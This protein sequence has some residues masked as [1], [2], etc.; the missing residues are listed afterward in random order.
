M[1]E[2]ADIMR[3]EGAG[4]ARAPGAPPGPS[5]ADSDGRLL[6]LWLHGK[7]PATVEAYRSDLSKFVDFTEGKPLRAVTLADVQEFADFVSELLAPASRARILA[8]LKSLFAF[9][10]QVGYLPFDVGR[11]VKLPARRDERAERMHSSHDV[12]SMKA[13]AKRG[14]DRA[15]LRAQKIWG[16]RV[17]QN[18]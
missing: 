16:L 8:A 15:L 11:P 4:L 10:H 2:R 14:R 18:V 13:H 7:S 1:V 3:A 6:G 9:G 17:T 5:G 12:H